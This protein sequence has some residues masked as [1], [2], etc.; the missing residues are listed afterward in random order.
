MEQLLQSLKAGEM[1]IVSLPNPHPGKGEVLVRTHFSAISTGTEGKTVSDARKGYIAKAKSRKEEVSKVVKAARSHGIADTYKMVMNKLEAL[2][3]LGYSLSGVVEKVGEGVKNFKPGDRVACGGASASH[4]ELVTIP[5][6]LCVSIPDAAAID[7]AAFTTIG[8]IAMQGIR[9]AEL[10]L[11]ENAVVIGLG[12]IG[13]ITLR[14][15]KSAGVRTFGIDLKEDL[16]DLAFQSGAENATVRGDELLEAKVNQFS[17]GNGVDAVIITAASSS[18]DPVELAGVLCRTHGKVVIVGSVPTG[19]SRKNY[20]R[21]ELELRMST[22]YGPGRY[23]A[24]YEEKGFDY[25]IGQVRWTENRNM[26][27]FT[28][29]LGNGSVQLAD[30]ISHRFAFENAREA[31]DLVVNREADKMG[32]LLEYDTAKPIA[33]ADQKIRKKVI[34]GDRVSFIGA[35]SFASNFLLPAIKDQVTLSGIATSRPHT[36]ENAARKY[37]FEKA[38]SDVSAMLNEDG[39][40]ACVIATRHDSHA[41]LAIEA[42]RSGKRVFLEKP[43]CLNIDEYFQL[44]S[45]LKKADTPDLM[46]GFN[47]RFSPLIQV[48][49]KKISGISCAINYRINAGAVPPD[50]WVHDPQIGGG[51]IIGEVCHFIDLC[52]YITESKVESI[53]A[54]AMDSTPQNHDTF[55]ASIRFENGSVAAI[56]YFSNGSKQVGKEFLE[57]FA[58]GMTAAVDDFKTMKISGAKT[59]TTK[60]S[61]QDKGHTPEFTAFAEAVKSGSP[62]PISIEEVLHATL[63]TFALVESIQKNGEQVFISEFEA[64]WN[65]PNAN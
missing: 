49:K 41:P 27:A 4:A 45:L 58:G 31:F 24:N 2:Q 1:E 56:S 37:G 36:A 46:V 63:S 9:R 43:L 7:E 35:G 3:P 26:Q 39:S 20:Y 10:N 50:H 33:N 21:K 44:K 52:S 59:E 13:Q 53:S 51:R 61:K 28:E 25:P 14:L 23:D 17:K 42:L 65:S 5:E 54:K 57:V 19:F 48:V 8:A 30:L 12:I 60:L 55:V 6:N 16:V 34:S 18:L 38:Y 15:L 11:G 32:I 40:A 62:F 29:L 64:Q 22:S 47:R